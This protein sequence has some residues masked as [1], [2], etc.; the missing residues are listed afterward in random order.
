[1]TNG[2][3]IRQMTDEDLAKEL[4]DFIINAIHSPAIFHGKVT[5]EQITVANLKWLKQ[6]YRRC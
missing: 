4:T 5:E 3:K 2:D 1:M 6:E